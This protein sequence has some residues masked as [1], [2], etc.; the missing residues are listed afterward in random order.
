ML[1]IDE[2]TLDV[3]PPPLIFGDFLNPAAAKEDRVYEE[4]SS[5]EKLRDILEVSTR[6][7]FVRQKPS[8]KLHMAYYPRFL[9]IVTHKLE[10]PK[11]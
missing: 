4:A 2:S 3:S 10:T 11:N 1:E 9:L 5:F 6:I 7:I 8:E